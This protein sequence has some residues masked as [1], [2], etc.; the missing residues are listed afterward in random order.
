MFRLNLNQVMPQNNQFNRSSESEYLPQENNARLSTTLPMSEQLIH[1]LLT[2]H[3]QKFDL[4][5]R[6][7]E[8]R[9]KELFQTYELALKHMQLETAY[10]YTVPK[11]IFNNK[12]LFYI[13]AV[14]ILLIV[15]CVFVYCLYNN[16]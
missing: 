14:I 3:K 7:I 11:Q 1:D 8:L 10:L 12:I 2:I 16:K 5:Q 4:K 6:E 9:E 15:S 13:T